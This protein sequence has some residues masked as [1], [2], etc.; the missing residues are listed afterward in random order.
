MFTG[1]NGKEVANS[2]HAA[3]SWS[4]GAEDR[5]PRVAEERIKQFWCEEKKRGRVVAI[6]KKKT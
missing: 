6:S 4:H 2:H 5:L 1:C 3:A